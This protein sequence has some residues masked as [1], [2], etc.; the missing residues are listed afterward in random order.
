MRRFH[1]LAWVCAAALAAAGTIA[2][3]GCNSSALLGPGEASGGGGGASTSS[4]SSS[5]GMGGS[6]GIAYGAS[7]SSS[8]GEVVCGQSIPDNDQD[9]Y[10]E[11]QGDCNDCDSSVNPDAVEGPAFGIDGFPLPPPAD[12]NCDGNIDEP[13]GN[14]DDALALASEDPFDA[15][16]AIGLCSHV[17]SAQWVL[18][19][20]GEIPTDPQKRAAFHLGHGILSQ[21][22]ANNSPSEGKKMLML[23]SGTARNTGDPGFVYRSFDKQY[24]S[25]SPYGS[26][27][28]LTCGDIPTG[29]AH[30]AAAV[31]FEIKMPSNARGFSFDY[32]FFT[33]AWSDHYCGN[34]ADFFVARVSPFPPFGHEGNIA[35][36]SLANLVSSNSDAWYGCACPGNPMGPCNVGGKQ[37]YCSYGDAPLLGTSFASDVANPGWSHASTGW[38]RTGVGNLVPGSTMRIRLATYDTTDGLLDSSTLIDNWQWRLPPEAPCVC[39]I[40]E[41][42]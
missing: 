1:D 31:E 7:S 34:G 13:T 27:P 20:G 4:S 11:E 38:L 15:V 23:S 37:F 8:S 3:V 21:F 39:G 25:N 14:C 16:R 22:G 24:T 18:A 2:A 33:Y 17:V 6:G 12:E 29:L 28:V 36:D 26:T 32:H 42:K 41:P 30:D 35:F 40:P 9:G 10:T 5:S 19:D